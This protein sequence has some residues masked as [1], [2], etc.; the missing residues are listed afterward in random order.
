MAEQ[1]AKRA[2][3][4]GCQVIAY[5]PS[6]AGRDPEADVRCAAELVALLRVADVVSLH[7]P[8]TPDTRHLIGRAMLPRMKADAIVMN[9]SRGA[10][11]DEEAL[12]E[13]LEDGRTGGVP[14]DALDGEPG[15]D[16]L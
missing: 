2:K 5:G 3:A 13:A 16:P 8:L 1:V 6:R 14:L 11:V 9:T 10:L 15:L 12:V 7:V 4:F